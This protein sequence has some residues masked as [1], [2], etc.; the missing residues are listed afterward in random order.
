MYIYTQF[1]ICLCTQLI[2]ILV[3]IG[4]YKNIGLY[5]LLLHGSGG[6]GGR[7][8]LV[9]VALSNNSDIPDTR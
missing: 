6:G 8:I 4:S 7:S 3:H 9:V 2:C 1:V 5:T